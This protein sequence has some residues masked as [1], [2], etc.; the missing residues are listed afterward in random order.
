MD[1]ILE[2]HIKSA[3][4]EDK[5]L[6]LASKSEVLVAKF[7]ASPYAVL[8]NLSN[9]REASSFILFDSRQHEQICFNDDLEVTIISRRTSDLTLGGKPP[10]FWNA[11]FNRHS[12]EIIA[13]HQPHLDF[14]NKHFVPE[15]PG[16]DVQKFPPDTKIIDLE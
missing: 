8:A 7:D 9:G 3:F 1:S 14:I 16:I 13:P 6:L 10:E 11:F 5:Y 12:T 4:E 2:Q 15:L